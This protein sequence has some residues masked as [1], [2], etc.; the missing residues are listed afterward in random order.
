MHE[1]GRRRA[2]RARKQSTTTWSLA[3]GCVKSTHL[4]AEVRGRA[5]RVVAVEVRRLAGGSAE[6]MRGVLGNMTHSL[7]HSLTH[8]PTS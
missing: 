4:L 1:V 2:R 3:V 7:T 8:S 6:S 5:Y